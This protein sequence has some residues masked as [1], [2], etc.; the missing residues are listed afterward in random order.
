MAA[1]TITSKHSQAY[2][3]D[4]FVIVR[5]VVSSDTVNRLSARFAPLFR[6]EFET[7]LLPDE[8]NWQEGRDDPSLTRQL[9]NAWKADREIA[10]TV[11]RADIGRACAQLGGWP[12]ARLNQDNLFWKPPG[13]QAIGFHQDSAYEQWVV[14]D[15]MVSC[16]IALD[17]TTAAGGTVEY[18][19]GSH[20][21]GAGP[22][23][24]GFHAPAA[25]FEDVIAAAAAAGVAAPERV[26]IEIN[27]G[28]AVFH[29]GWTWH[30]SG[31]NLSAASRRALVVH[32]M[33]STARY[34][35]TNIGP[36]YGRYKRFGD[37]R[38]D[39]SF[40]PIM[41]REDGYCSP[42]IG[43]MQSAGA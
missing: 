36:V 32:C 39:E 2:L 26:P 9:C 1:L 10:S 27:A 35:E 5:N 41:W 22:Q 16:W 37:T 3:R 17:Q 15:D 20:R 30:G 14:P 34:H 7:G 21:W 4:G 42:L 25:P 38:M 40:F 12:G 19:R 18:V 11:L 29:H 24:V 33:T 13:A 31:A 23:R 43:A 28:D 8:V 6:G